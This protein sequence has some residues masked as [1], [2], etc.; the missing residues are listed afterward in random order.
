MQKHYLIVISLLFIS[1]ISK[2]QYNDDKEAGT[3]LMK[4]EKQIDE[5]VVNADMDFLQDAY[6]DDFRF[7]HSD[8]KVDDKAAWLNDVEKGK[9]SL[10]SRTLDK[11]EV[12]IHDNVGVTNGILTVKRK[13]GT[14]KLQYVRVY[15]R[16][17]DQ[18]QMIMHRSVQD[19][20]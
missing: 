10:L 2:A 15:I 19:I 16:K 5:A 7:K 1:I 3:A 11:V 18:W 20:K 17:D 4:F 14:Y 13:N 8:G 12:E 6:A 9:G